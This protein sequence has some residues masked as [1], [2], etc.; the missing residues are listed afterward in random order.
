MSNLKVPNFQLVSTAV[1]DIVNAIALA[2]ARVSTFVVD[3][4]IVKGPSDELAAEL[5]G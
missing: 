4:V 3:D 2:L 5:L 1:F